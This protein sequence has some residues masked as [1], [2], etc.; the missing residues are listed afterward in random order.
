MSDAIDGTGVIL[1]LGDGATPTEVFTAVAELVDI[2]G[3]GIKRDARE[4]T[5]HQSTD[6]F[7]EFKPGL[8]DGGEVG[9]TVN[10]LPGNATH[11]TASGGLLESINDDELH[12]WKVV[13]PE[14]D[15]GATYD[16]SFA[17]FLTSFDVKYPKGDNMTADITIKVS[18]K[19]TLAVVV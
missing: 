17:G 1:K 10:L 9:L 7:R 3:P 19:P 12:N 11:G 2:N 6:K 4:T 5:H 15:A 13:L 18:G 14:D 8:K 16:W